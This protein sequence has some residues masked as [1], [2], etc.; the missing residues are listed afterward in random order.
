MNNTE[1]NQTPGNSGKVYPSGYA[2]Y[3][4]LSYKEKP[5]PR[6]DLELI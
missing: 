6:E 5:T 4:L 1:Q 3:E 2:E